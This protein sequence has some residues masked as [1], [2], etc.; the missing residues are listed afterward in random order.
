MQ[1]LGVGHGGRTFKNPGLQSPSVFGNQGKLPRFIHIY[2]YM[3][4]YLGKGPFG[5][6]A[7]DHIMLALFWGY[8]PN[9]KL[10]VEM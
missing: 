6:L 7:I 10:L 3:G 2:L 9:M 5:K 1:R 4:A 8:V